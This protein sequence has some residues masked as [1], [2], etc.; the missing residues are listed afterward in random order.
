M[1]NQLLQRK[2]TNDPDWGPIVKNMQG[3]QEVSIH[4]RSHRSWRRWSKNKTLPWRALSNSLRTSSR[5]RNVSCNSNG[6]S[7][8]Q[9]SSWVCKKTM[10]WLLMATKAARFRRKRWIRNAAN[11]KQPTRSN[12]KCKESQTTRKLPEIWTSSVAKRLCINHMVVSRPNREIKHLLAAQ[13]IRHQMRSLLKSK[14]V[15]SFHRKKDHHSKKQPFQAESSQGQ[16]WKS[17]M[18]RKHGIEQLL[19]GSKERRQDNFLLWRRDH[20]RDKQVSIR[21]VSPSYLPTW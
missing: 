11:R 1:Y 7:W 2:A 10:T 4:F 21:P 15:T 16:S 9:N 14:R 3:S 19:V 17:V 6:D 18:L 13:R 5:A 12:Q 20:I 8:L